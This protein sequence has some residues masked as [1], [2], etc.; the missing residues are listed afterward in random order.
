MSVNSRLI[1]TCYA[2]ATFKANHKPSFAHMQ[3][4]LSHQ[5]PIRWLVSSSNDPITV[6]DTC[7]KSAP[8]S[9]SASY[10]L[11]RLWH[12]L[13]LHAVILK[14]TI[15]CGRVISS[16]S[17]G[18]MNGLRLNLPDTSLMDMERVLDHA[19]AMHVSSESLLSHAV[20]SGKMVQ[21]PINH[22]KF[23][24]FYLHRRVLLVFRVFQLVLWLPWFLHGAQF[25]VKL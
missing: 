1:T 3:I 19:S 18:Q 2:R 12:L 24:L 7:L 5:G 22:S 16:S 10:C 23:T 8:P 13:A 21:S 6:A 9:F 4:K 17:V 11:Y 15:W 25:I 20:L 14:D